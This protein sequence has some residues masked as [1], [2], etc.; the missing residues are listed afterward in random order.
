MR[1]GKFPLPIE[2]GPED[3]R[4]TKVAWFASEVD[5]WIDARPRRKIGG[6]SEHRAAQED[7]PRKPKKAVAR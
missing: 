4:T 2:L 1:D 3:G 6:L 5:A 7:S